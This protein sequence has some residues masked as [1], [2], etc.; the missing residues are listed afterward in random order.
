MSTSAYV[1]SSIA[2]MRDV[3][4]CSSTAAWFPSHASAATLSATR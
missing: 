1:G 3:H 2:S 4:A